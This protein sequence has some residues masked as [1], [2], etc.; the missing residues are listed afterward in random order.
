MRLNIFSKS[1]LTRVKYSFHRG[2]LFRCYDIYNKFNDSR[3]KEFTLEY[4]AV[5]DAED[6]FLFFFFR[7]EFNITHRMANII[8]SEL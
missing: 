1:I 3:Q 2:N 6:I 4:F 5:Q 7:V 8:P